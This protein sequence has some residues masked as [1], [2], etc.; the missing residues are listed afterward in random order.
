[1]KT[2]ITFT[3][4]IDPTSNSVFAAI[5]KSN[6]SDSAALDFINAI[7]THNSTESCSSYF[8]PYVAIKT[9]E[10]NEK[11]Y[12]CDENTMLACYEITNDDGKR[13]LCDI[14]LNDAEHIDKKISAHWSISC[15]AQPENDILPVINIWLLKNNNPNYEDHPDYHHTAFFSTANGIKL[16]QY[17]AFH[18]LELQ[19]WQMPDEPTKADLWM[20]I[21]SCEQHHIKH[22]DILNN[23]AMLS[24][25]EAM[26]NISEDPKL[27]DLYLTEKAMSRDK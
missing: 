4:P 25:V 22:P 6:N 12:F 17:T 8:S 16:C 21:L 14:H 11:H 1:M 9:L 20:S 23:P 10:P 26:H 7:I 13:M 5:F 15:S 24:A 27:Y 18:Q 2:A 3:H 19:K